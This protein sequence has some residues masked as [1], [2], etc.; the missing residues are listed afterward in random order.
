MPA[1]SAQ[2]VSLTPELQKLIAEKVATGHYRSAS[3]VVRA[4]LRHFAGEDNPTTVTGVGVNPETE[5]VTILEG[6][7][8][9]FYAMDRDFRITRYNSACTRHFG[10]QP[11]EVLGRVLWDVFPNAT[12]TALGRKF[13]EVM[14]TRATVKGE[15]P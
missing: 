13:A 14:R 11:S 4:A 15:T 6:I 7:G 9:G 2:N 3:E 12:D 8:E 10:K 1:R 5:L